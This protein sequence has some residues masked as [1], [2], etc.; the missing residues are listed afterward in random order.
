MCRRTL[1]IVQN[2][3]PERLGAAVCHRAPRLFEVTWKALQPFIDP[4]TRRKVVFLKRQAKRSGVGALLKPSA[5]ADSFSPDD[6]ETTT[7]D[8]SQ[9]GQ[10][11]DLDRL[12]TSFGGRF[13]G[14]RFSIDV[15]EQWMMREDVQRDVELAGAMAAAS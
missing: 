7:Q 10:Q 3:Y 6:G 13:A 9:L 14:A 8:E 4:V 15:F 1:A 12:H 2:F 11:F 5:S